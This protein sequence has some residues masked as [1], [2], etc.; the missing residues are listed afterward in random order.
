M[1]RNESIIT[2]DLNRVY[3]CNYPVMK[4]NFQEFFNVFISEMPHYEE[5][6]EKYGRKIKEVSSRLFDIISYDPKS[7]FISFLNNYIDEEFNKYMNISSR[8]IGLLGKDQIFNEYFNWLK[9][10][11]LNFLRSHNI[12][13]FHGDCLIEFDAE[14]PTKEIIKVKISLPIK[15]FAE[16]LDLMEL[17]LIEQEESLNE[18]IEDYYYRNQIL[19]QF[20]KTYFIIRSMYE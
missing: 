3:Q 16:I 8:F 17:F 15:D 9:K 11:I 5:Y 7:L 14:D 1:I 2:H 13:H 19:H 20:K 6:W 10:Y 12:Y 18:F 4:G